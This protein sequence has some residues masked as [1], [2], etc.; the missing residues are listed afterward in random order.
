MSPSK[1]ENSPRELQSCYRSELILRG[2]LKDQYGKFES[3]IAKIR[4]VPEIENYF[5]T[6]NYQRINPSALRYK[7]EPSSESA[8]GKGLRGIET[9]EKKKKE[10]GVLL[11]QTRE[12]LA[13]MEVE[14]VT[15]GV[16]LPPRQGELST[17]K[18]DPEPETKKESKGEKMSK[19]VTVIGWDDVPHLSQEAK[20]SLLSVIPPHEREARTKGVPQDRAKKL[21]STEQPL[22]P[23]Q[24]EEREAEDAISMGDSIRDLGHTLVT[25]FKELQETLQVQKARQQQ[26]PGS[27]ARLKAAKTRAPSKDRQRKAK[28]SKFH[29]MGGLQGKEMTLTVVSNGVMRARAHGVTEDYSYQDMGF[30]DR[31][32]KTSEHNHLWLILLAFARRNNQSWQDLAKTTSRQPAKR[33][34]VEAN[35]ARLRAQLCSFFGLKDNP[36]QCTKGIYKPTFKIYFEKEFLRLASEGLASTTKSDLE[37]AYEDD[38]NP[39]HLSPEKLDLLK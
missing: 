18:P 15:Q 2:E 29:S 30:A 19:H 3:T 26:S 13:Q 39:R 17:P 35:I 27:Q 4:S 20:D 23:A 1:K 6:L 14:A 34:A 32:H 12:R 9:L 24:S 16:E 38:C 31:R 11:A 33:S 5:W 25:G 7:Q 22:K 28:R 21:D 36:I 10:T 37:E 8:V